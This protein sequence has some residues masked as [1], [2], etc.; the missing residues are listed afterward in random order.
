[1]LG[2]D[3]LLFNAVLRGYHLILEE[4]Q[5]TFVLEKLHVCVFLLEIEFF[6][7]KIILLI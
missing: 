7:N 3:W 6:L 5:Q 4:S 1:M 2:P